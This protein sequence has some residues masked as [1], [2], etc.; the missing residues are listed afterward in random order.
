MYT[1][2]A[3]C[4]RFNSLKCLSE[5]NRYTKRSTAATRFF[6]CFAILGRNKVWVLLIPL[7]ITPRNGSR[8]LEAQGGFQYLHED[9]INHPRHMHSFAMDL[10]SHVHGNRPRDGTQKDFSRCNSVFA[11]NKDYTVRFQ[12]QKRKG[13]A[14]AKHWSGSSMSSSSLSRT[15]ML[16]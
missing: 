6:L 14:R 8:L 1:G 4:N 2:Q 9:L 13:H 5:A 10:D 16:Y 11:I 15:Q 7:E 12:Y 3:F